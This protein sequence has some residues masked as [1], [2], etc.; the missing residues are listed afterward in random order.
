M[1]NIAVVAHASVFAFGFV[2]ALFSR[3]AGPKAVPNNAK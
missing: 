3:V 2:Q 1:T